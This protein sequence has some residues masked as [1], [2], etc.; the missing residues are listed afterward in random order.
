MK[1][2]N[3]QNST[4]NNSNMLPASLVFVLWLAVCILLFICMLSLQI[5]SYLGQGFGV[6]LISD[7]LS[8]YPS[9]K[10]VA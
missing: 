2:N 6:T 4:Q 5:V 7:S 8:A 10:L 3:K 9:V 1:V